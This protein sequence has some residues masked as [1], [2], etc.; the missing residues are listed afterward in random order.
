M[1]VK[2]II[3]CLL[4]IMPVLCLCACGEDQKASVNATEATTTSI[5][6]TTTVPESTQMEITAE[7]LEGTWISIKSG[8]E[9]F[10]MPDENE[11]YTNELCFL[12][13]GT[14]LASDYDYFY[15]CTGNGI[16]KWVPGGRSY[17]G[18]CG[19]YQVE[20][21]KVIISQMYNDYVDYGE[22]TIT[23]EVLY[24]DGDTLIIDDSWGTYVRAETVVRGDLEALC[25]IIG[26]EYAPKEYEE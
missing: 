8:D 3:A 19:K 16:W 11:L 22:E 18:L 20:D 10:P 6:P 15:Q 25:K 13:N 4:C 17:E 24:F 7:N 14:Y 5:P 2:K 23:Y 21:G 12:E 9:D 26:I 1:S